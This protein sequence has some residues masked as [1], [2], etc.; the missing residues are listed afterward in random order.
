MSSQNAELFTHF[1]AAMFNGRASLILE[2]QALISMRIEVC[3]SM[4]HIVRRSH[5]SSN[6]A[7]GT[8]NVLLNK[9]IDPEV[10]RYIERKVNTVMQAGLREQIHVKY[11]LAFNVETALPSC[12]EENKCLHD[13]RDD[14]LRTEIQMPLTAV[15]NVFILFALCVAVSVIVLIVEI[16]WYRFN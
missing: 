13:I 1:S 15:S 6:F 9:L 5:I 14:D 7:E 11:V 10:R 3:A 12:W 2:Q 8:Q 4:P 16:I